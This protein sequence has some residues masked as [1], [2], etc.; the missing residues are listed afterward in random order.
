MAIVRMQ[1]VAIV[2]PRSLQED[3]LASVQEAGMVEVAV[4]DALAGGAVDHSEANFRIAELDYAIATL[5]DI[6]PKEVQSQVARPVTEEDVLAASSSADVRGI[7]DELHSLEA[8]DEEARRD[9]QAAEQT[10]ETLAP[11]R[12]YDL[13]LESVRETRTTK[14]LF[15]LLPPPAVVSFKAEMESRLP[16]CSVRAIGE[17]ESSILEVIAWKD[18]LVKFEEMATR[19]GWTTVEPPAG[20]GFVSAL[21]EEALIRTQEAQQTLQKNAQRRIAL[22]AQLPALS[23][24]KTFTQWLHAKQSARETLLLT[25][26]TSTLIGWMPSRQINELSSKL[27]KIDPAVVLLHVEPKE[28]EEAPVLLK[29]KVWVTPF[30]SVTT[31][32][33][34]PLSS[35]MDPTSALSPFFALFFALC[36]TDGGYGLAL[37]LIM[38]TVLLLKKPTPEQSP[39][40]WTLFLSGIVSILVGIPFGGWFGLTPEQA[41]SFM[42]ETRA[43]GVMWFR[44]Q[45]WN[46]GKQDGI[47]FLQNLALAL[48]ITHLFFGMFL[49]G[50]H[51][52]I[53]GAKA[54]AFWVNFTSHLLLGA[55]LFAAFAPADLK[56]VATYVLYAVVA[57]NIW[58]KG[59]GSAWYIRPIMGFLGL[60]NFA[61]GLLSNGLSYLRILALGLVTGAMALAVNKVAEEMGKL[62]P[63]YL[64]IPVMIVI[65]IGGHTVSIALNTLGS[66]IHAGRL[67]FIEFFGQ[68]FEGGGRPFSPLSRPTKQS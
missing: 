41:P 57:L 39:L 30:Q 46:L 13:P 49:A 44:G 45:V 40:L 4:S 63:V 50:W 28:G 47:T 61:I 37:T 19:F 42:T 12:S 60:M 59:Y 1:K 3:V 67:Q 33:G 55:A 2:T 23:R 58:G 21:Y 25:N 15:G 27:R 6:A 32:Y 20:H 53:H 24:V 66:F 64:A 14:R 29:N 11:W 10:K 65:A 36:L 5:R 22:S 48:G 26:R 62:F 35:E 54:E 43:D 8:D 38:G 68:F 34:L 51:K 52:W 7:V 9:A 17:G 31:L 16:R 18:D 56:Q